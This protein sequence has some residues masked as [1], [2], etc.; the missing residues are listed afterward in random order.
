MNLLSQNALT[1]NDGINGTKNVIVKGVLEIEQLN[2]TVNMDTIF[3][4]AYYDDT[5][6]LNPVIIEVK[7]KVITETQQQALYQAVKGALPDINVDYSAWYQS[8]LYES[9][10][11]EMATTFQIPTADITIVA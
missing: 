4:Y 5:D 7:S 3:Q 10:R 9:F 1:V 8:L 11:V 2:I 6:P